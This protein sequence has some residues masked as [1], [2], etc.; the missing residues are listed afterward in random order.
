MIG[1]ES[2]WLMMHTTLAAAIKVDGC[3]HLLSI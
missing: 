3:K 1:L 2:L